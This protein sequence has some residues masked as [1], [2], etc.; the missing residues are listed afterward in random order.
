MK[1][2]ARPACSDKR[3]PAGLHPQRP[4][5]RD[6]PARAAAGPSAPGL[7][8]PTTTISATQLIW[9]FFAARPKP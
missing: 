7:D 3:S 2:D 4:L 1:A 9:E 6:D 8:Q 5:R